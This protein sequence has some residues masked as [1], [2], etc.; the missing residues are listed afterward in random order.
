M[1]N[2]NNEGENRLNDNAQSQFT[3]EQN[4]M[5][6]QQA[7]YVN[8]N[9]NAQTPK[10]SQNNKKKKG[11]DDINWN[12]NSANASTI[13]SCFAIVIDIIHKLLR[14]LTFSYTG[15][16]IFLFI[17]SGILSIFALISTLKHSLKD[18]NITIDGYLCGISLILLILI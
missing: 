13:A 5:M 16:I 1:S 17:L 9:E 2:F 12:I 15:L 7:Q 8:N 3:N 14:M 10:N 11:I 4:N 18:K 6:N